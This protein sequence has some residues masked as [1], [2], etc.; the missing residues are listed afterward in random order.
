MGNFG[1]PV[2]EGHQFTRHQRM[3]MEAHRLGTYSYREGL[4]TEYAR[5]ESIF[6]REIPLQDPFLKWGIPT[7]V[8]PAENILPDPYSRSG[9]L[10]RELMQIRRWVSKSPTLKKYRVFGRRRFNRFLNKNPTPPLS[11]SALASVLQNAWSE[12]RPQWFHSRRGNAPIDTE[13]TTSLFD[14]AEV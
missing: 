5:I 2:P 6:Q 4:H 7:P 10:S 8:L 9:G 12:S 1:L 13:V 11:G 3:W 14:Y